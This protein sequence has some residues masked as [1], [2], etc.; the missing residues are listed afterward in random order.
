MD[1]LSSSP[2]K[3]ISG[4]ALT[5]IRQLQDESIHCCVT[6]PPYWQLRDYGVEGQIGQE[7]TPEEYVEKLVKVFREVRRILK[8]DG[9]LWINIGDKY[10]KKQLLGL[11]W[12]LALALQTD[13]WVLRSE[14]IWHKPN[15]MPE[16]VKDRPVVS[17]EHIFMF[18]KSSTYYYGLN[19]IRE[20]Y[21]P[22]AKLVRSRKSAFG[23]AL[24]GNIGGH[25][26]GP[27]FLVLDPRGKNIRT[28]WTINVGNSTSDHSAMFPLELAERCIKAGCP[29]GGTAL[30]CF[31][32][33]ATTGVAAIAN[34]RQY[35]GIEINCQ[36]N[37]FARNRLDEAIQKQG[38]CLTKNNQTNEASIT[39]YRGVTNM[40]STDEERLEELERRL[41]VVRDR[42]R[43]VATGHHAGFYL[44]GRAGTSKTYTVRTTLERDEVPYV[45]QNGHIT[46]RGLFEIFQ[47]FD[48]QVIVLDDVSTIF[49]NDRARN[50]LL[51]ALGNQPG[52][53]DARII[54]YRKANIV[55]RV[56][57]TGGIIAIS[58]L[59]LH[60]SEL[61]EALK[62]RVNYMNYNPSDEQII[63]LLRMISRQKQPGLT[64]SECDEV[65]EYLIE[66]CER[67]T[68]RP[69]VRLLVDKAFKD[70]LL[71]KRGESETHWKDLVTSTLEEQLVSLRFEPQKRLSRS[72]QM[73]MERKLAVDIAAKHNSREDRIAAWAEATGKSEDAFYRRLREVDVH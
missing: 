20:P 34:E 15:G 37:K 53:S 40:L 30:D 1:N 44:F 9:T 60:G 70:F 8:P 7:P 73:D 17:H 25:G 62:S 57:F 55:E 31:S 54:T 56:R 58:N 49:R 6:S 69:D 52:G 43:G 61:L 16:S 33:H 2:Y 26:N 11:P 22:G 35:V 27:E 32:G 18:T 59:E 19:D 45:Y 39:Y 41:T 42:V 71:F 51:A 4:D 67:L 63:A 66:E 64:A 46:P 12:Q 10:E 65:C 5:A 24:R 29:K 13:D 48:S 47:E 68:F 3:I 36:Y 28:V 23:K 50:I 38:S 14:V 21:V 72:E